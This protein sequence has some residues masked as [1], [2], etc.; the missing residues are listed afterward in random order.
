MNGVWV[1][2]RI[3]EKTKPGLA[4]TKYGDA[5]FCTAILEDNTGKI[6]VN[7][8]RTQT[9]VNVGDQVRIESG[10]TSPFGDLNI[11]RRGRIVVLSRLPQVE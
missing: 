11:G 4:Q 7:L 1:E 9:Q 6:R 8:Y 3:A 2:G 10:F 5:L